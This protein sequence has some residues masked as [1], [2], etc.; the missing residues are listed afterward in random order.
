MNDWTDWDNHGRTDQGTHDANHLLASHKHCN[1]ISSEWYPSPK[2]NN[3]GS[4]DDVTSPRAVF[5]NGKVYKVDLLMSIRM[6]H[7]EVWPRCATGSFRHCGVWFLTTDVPTW[8][9]TGSCTTS[10]E[11]SVAGREGTQHVTTDNSLW[12]G[13]K[14]MCF[15]KSFTT[16]NAYIIIFRGQ[17]QCSELS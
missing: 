6:W 3:S 10:P 11:L 1:S 15:K 13:L 8:R 4:A 12:T 14:S 16:L 2:H 9:Q 17:V 7:K 5:G